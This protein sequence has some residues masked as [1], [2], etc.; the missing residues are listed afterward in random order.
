[1]A[2]LVNN[3]DFY[4]DHHYNHHDHNDNHS[5]IDDYDSGPGG[6]LDYNYDE[7]SNID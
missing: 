3:Y 2:D 4:Y 5:N 7:C 1:M 6:R